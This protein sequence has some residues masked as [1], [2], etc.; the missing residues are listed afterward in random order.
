MADAWA[1]LGSSMHQAFVVC[2]REWP[3][4]SVALVGLCTW[5]ACVPVMTMALLGEPI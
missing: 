4:L 3:A 1:R 2:S 5:Y